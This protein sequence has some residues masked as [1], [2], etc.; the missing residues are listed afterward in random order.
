[1]A[2]HATDGVRTARG[3]PPTPEE[4]AR[5]CG[6]AR[7][8]D[9]A[10]ARLRA[11]RYFPAE[12]G[13]LEQ[14]V[15]AGRQAE[16]LLVRG[17]YGLICR[18]V[19][20]AESR[21]SPGRV[22]RDDLLQLGALAFLRACR[23]YRPDAGRL[24]TFA[25]YYVR[26]A[27]LQ[28][29]RDAADLSGGYGGDLAVAL[30]PYLAYLQRE[31]GRE[32][33]AKELADCFNEASITRLSVGIASTPDWQGAPAAEVR[34]EA[35]RRVRARGMFLDAEWVAAILRRGETMLRLDAAAVGNEERRRRGGGVVL[36]EVVAEDEAR[37]AEDDALS[38]IDSAR[39]KALV[40]VADRL[41]AALGRLPTAAEVAEQANAAARAELAT[42][43][44]RE[45]GRAPTPEE[46]AKRAAVEGRREVS[47]DAVQEVLGSLRLVEHDEAPALLAAHAAAVMEV[48][49]KV[50]GPFE[51]A[52]VTRLF[53]LS[54]R[55]PMSHERL[56][57]EMGVAPH[58]IARLAERALAKL[59]G[60]PALREIA[61]ATGAGAR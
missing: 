4:T 15:A 36:E 44:G 14:A 49:A 24:S 21:L 50:L 34:A 17:H 48:V 18:L 45:L 3:A 57:K 33:S 55:A 22:E 9:E 25:A 11:G 47:P 31:L 29:H 32:P 60:S 8:G 41:A 12:R 5:L 30:R 46:V 59:E 58:V 28:A 37:S 38:A 20:L 52:I 39:T 1:M 19:V 23:R 13:E 7:E 53:G 40:Q 6:L 56:A 10:A 61:V 27:V 43:L 26:E 35:E 42:R 51:L 54:G 16:Q 2:R